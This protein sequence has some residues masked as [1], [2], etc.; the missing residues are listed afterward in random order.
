MEKKGEEQ[1]PIFIEGQYLPGSV[2]VAW[3]EFFYLVH[4]SCEV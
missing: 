2:L 3:R 1:K 4:Q